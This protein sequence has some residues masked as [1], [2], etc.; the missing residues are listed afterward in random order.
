MY[1]TYKN[2]HPY[3]TN[4]L[5]ECSLALPKQEGCYLNLPDTSA[6]DSPLDIQTIHGSHQDDTELLARKEKHSEL[7]FENQIREFKMMCYANSSENRSTKWRIALPKKMVKSKVKW[8]H[9]V[10]RQPIK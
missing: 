2:F 3:W 4:Q 5:A 9:I 6:V 8:F 7:H 1:D 10:T